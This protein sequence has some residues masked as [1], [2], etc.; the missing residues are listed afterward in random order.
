[1]KKE[2]NNELDDDELEDDELEVVRKPVQIK[3][4]KITNTE[5]MSRIEKLERNIN[6]LRKQF[7]EEIEDTK[8]VIQDINISRINELY[9]SIDLWTSD[10]SEGINSMTELGNEIGYFLQN[11]EKIRGKPG[12]TT[13]DYIQYQIKMMAE[14]RLKIYDMVHLLNE[15]TLAADEV[16]RKINILL[17]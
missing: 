7:S 5:V 16:K 12:L 15:K 6:N 14:L 13:D 4:L 8:K 1:M 10:V 2:T 9:S 11:R 17:S 3:Q